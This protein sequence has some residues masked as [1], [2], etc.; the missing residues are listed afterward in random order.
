[1]PLSRLPILTQDSAASQN[2]WKSNLGRLGTKNSL[3]HASFVS[4]PFANKL[5][6]W[7]GAIPHDNTILSARSP[8]VLQD[9]FVTSTLNEA[10]PLL[11]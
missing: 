9:S 4:D 5:S 7:Q 6:S 2:V 1:M 10:I 8:D 3:L 11:G